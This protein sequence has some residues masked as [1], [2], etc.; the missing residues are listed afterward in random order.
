MC[1]P[2][3]AQSCFDGSDLHLIHSGDPAVSAFAGSYSPD[4]KYIVFRLQDHGSFALM[5]MRSDGS[6]LKQILGFSS[7]KPRLID[8]GPR[9]QG[10]D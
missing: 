5:Q 7:F 6:H 2:S 10:G 8:W 1:F 9:T 3:G 4:G